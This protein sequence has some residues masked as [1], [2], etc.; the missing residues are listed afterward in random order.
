MQT[1]EIDR[2]QDIPLVTSRIFGP[3]GTRRVQLVFDTGTAK[4]QFHTPVL[5]SIG[6]SAAQAIHRLAIGFLKPFS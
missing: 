1:F 5:E 6:Y 2:S 3:R 4:T